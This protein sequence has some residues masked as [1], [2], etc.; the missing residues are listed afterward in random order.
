MF[1][2]YSHH[3]RSVK[4]NPKR[5]DDVELIDL[6]SDDSST[7]T[8]ANA[9]IG[10]QLTIVDEVID[11]NNDVSPNTTDLQVFELRC[12]RNYLIIVIK[13]R[14]DDV[15]MYETPPQKYYAEEIIKI[16]LDPNIDARKYVTSNQLMLMQ[17][18]HIL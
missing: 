16:L 1:N 11:M 15:P 7:S 2:H 4:H 8:G 13:C 17:V 10:T 5:R 6:V 14:L 9:D 18:Q 3:W 12:V